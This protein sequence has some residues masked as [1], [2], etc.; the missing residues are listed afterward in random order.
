MDAMT[1]GRRPD[2]GKV[3]PGRLVLVV[4]PSGA[5]KDTLIAGAREALAV[6]AGF[7][8]ARRLVTRPA[9]PALE[10]HDSIDETNF[11]AM[12]DAG[13]FALS[14][15]AHGLCYAVPGTVDQAI[16]KGATAIAN[17]SRTVIGEARA[18]YRDLLVVQV[19]A[20]SEVLRDRL[21][22]R[23]RETAA[24]IEERVARAAAM[25]VSGPDVVTID[26]SGDIDEAVAVFLAAIR[27]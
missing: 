3:G 8:F 15:R 26:N 11:D 20:R 25:A 1:Q 12:R 6:D 9:D 23:G 7:V 16:G 17:T 27:A 13:A 4:G 5:G 14:W 21:S 2:D 19:T 22:R 24:D 18:K 10:D